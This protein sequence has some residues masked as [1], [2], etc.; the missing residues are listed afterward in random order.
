MSEAKT[1]TQYA[2]YI[3]TTSGRWQK[4]HPF[5]EKS[6]E[7]A[8]RT[9]ENHREIVTLPEKREYKIAARQVTLTCGEWV[10]LTDAPRKKWPP[11]ALM[12][13][14]EIMRER[15]EETRQKPAF[16][17]NEIIKNKTLYEPDK[18][19]AVVMGRVGPTG[20]SWIR[21]KLTENGYKAVEITGSIYDH[22][23][24]NDNKN[25]LIVDPVE[26]TITI[27]L[28]RLIYS[29]DNLKEVEA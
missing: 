26:G 20:K 12:T 7:G 18:F 19:T 4:I 14:A 29:H 1:Y 24:Y 9:I 28:N 2:A 16:I 3:K 27:I 25:R 13:D 10:D 22:V 17:L 5:Y 6:V 11:R 15:D 8:K 23:E 21:Q